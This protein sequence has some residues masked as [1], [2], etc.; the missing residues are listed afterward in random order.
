MKAKYLILI[1]LIA[2]TWL[3]VSAAKMDH[4][5]NDAK[6]ICKQYNYDN[7]VSIQKIDGKWY[8][9]CTNIQTSRG[10]FLIN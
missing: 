3:I 6:P 5:L 8:V 2:I 4:K 7:T 10:H 9:N 1:V